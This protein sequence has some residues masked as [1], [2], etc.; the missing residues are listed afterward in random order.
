MFRI[1]HQPTQERADAGP[2]DDRDRARTRPTTAGPAPARWRPPW[3]RTPTGPCRRRRTAARS[4]RSS[5]RSR[6]STIRKVMTPARSPTLTPSQPHARITR[7]MTP[8]SRR[9]HIACIA[10]MYAP[11]VSSASLPTPRGAG[12]P[13]AE[14]FVASARRVGCAHERGTAGPA[15]A[16]RDPA[17]ADAARVAGR[18]HH[19]Q[20]RAP[21][22]ARPDL[23][24]A[25]RLERADAAPDG[26]GRLGRSRGAAA[27]R[28]APARH[29]RR[30]WA[31][32]P[33]R[34]SAR[35]RRGCPSPTR[36]R[37]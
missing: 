14:P 13:V 26:T 29:R 2:D 31:G 30:P 17:R 8:G 18:S 11:D 33:S 37:G 16:T 23:G 5:R 3:W 19:R 34:R 32:S 28:A 35:S 1:A 9:G 25:G 22:A 4:R 20:P 15:R 36:S 12:S 7:W 27:R 10:E 24:R 21:G 6:Q